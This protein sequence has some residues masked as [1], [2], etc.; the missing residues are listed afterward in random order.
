MCGITGY[1][2]PEA[3]Y[4]RET[5]AAMTAALAHRG[6]DAD[7]FFFDEQRKVGLGHRRLSIIDLSEAANQPMFS[8]NGRFAY[9][10]NGEVYNYRD[11]SRQYAGILPALRTHSD[12]ELILELFAAL[13]EASL[14]LLNGMF[15]FALYDTQQGQLTL[16]RDRIGIKPLY[17]YFDGKNLAFASEIK[18]LLGLPGINREVDHQ[19]L[20][21]Y[22]HLGYIPSD[23]SAFLHIRKLPQGHL[24]RFDGKQLQIL[25]YWR[26][27]QQIEATVLRDEQAALAELER[28]M[29]SSV[30]YQM[31]SDVPIGVF[32]SGGVDSSL[33]TALACRVSPEKINTFSI[34]F[35]DK[36][37]DESGFARSVSKYLGTQHH[38]LIV[39]ER[40]ALDLVDDLISVYDEPFADSSTL[41][42]MLV[43]RMA[44]QEVKV[45]L[46]GDGGDELF[47]GYGMYNW[48]RRLNVPW[49]KRLRKPIAAALSLMPERLQRAALVLDYPGEEA[50][51]SHIFSQ[52][53]YFF[54]E[55]ALSKLMVSP[56]AGGA[57]INRQFRLPE[58]RQLDPVEKQAFF[59]LKYYLP[60]DLLV[61]VD[62]ASMF[63]SLET[64]VPFL[65]HRVV[66]F[67]L[68]LDMG[69]KKHKSADKYL[70]KAL[71]YRYVPPHYFDRPKWGFSL[72]LRRWLRQELRYLIDLYLNEELV[73]SVGWVHYE[74]VRE[75]KDAYLGG[76]DYHYNRV[77]ALALLHKFAIEKCGYH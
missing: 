42:T 55:K 38:E 28:L 41:P 13:G 8:H 60:D 15:A 57:D 66:N 32:L 51:V 47:Y 22:L 30:E 17:Y 62:R 56:P 40:D 59:D 68:N 67:A 19:A 14:E 44:R 71:L 10:Y 75:L 9:V 74:P 3:S 61:K 16:V 34:G 21:D 76:V 77:W 54:S 24:L 4:N 12:T 11:L 18:G 2:A 72:P 48:A 52:E 35:Q 26:P 43:S 20:Y 31:I 50:L 5:L 25:P 23:R 29:L 37:Y 36:T 73:R 7:G 6:P 53:Q 45:T 70:L 69:L 39:T 65:D 49:V 33:I 1:Y 64:R 58:A 46:S 63:Y 27:E